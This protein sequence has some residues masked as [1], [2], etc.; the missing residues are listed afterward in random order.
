MCDVLDEDIDGDG[1]DNQFDS[2]DFDPNEWND[3]DSD[4]IGDNSD[5]DDAG[6]G[7]Y[8]GVEEDCLSDPLD[9]SSTPE[10]TD[11]DGVC[12]EL[13][14]DVDGDGIGTVSYTHLTLPTILLV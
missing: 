10:D 12:D 9:P 6:D 3:T 14:D 8:D 11:S 13:D 7:F 1:Y 5:G 2:F 4:G